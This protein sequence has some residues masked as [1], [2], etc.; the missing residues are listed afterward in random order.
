VDFIFDDVDWQIRYLVI[1]AKRWFHKRYVLVAPEW[2]TAIDWIS[3]H[4]QLDLTSEQIKNSP[5]VNPDSPLDTQ[6]E[7]RISAYF[8]HP[9]HA[10]QA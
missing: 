4:I 8:G 3:R 10:S 1:E 9:P 6:T 5:D 7:F 2:A